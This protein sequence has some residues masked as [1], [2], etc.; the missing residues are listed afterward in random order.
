MAPLHRTSLLVLPLLLAVAAAAGADPGG[1]PAPEI[2]AEVWLNG[3]PLSR[4]ALLG[5][6][7]LV[8]FWTFACHN[9]QNVEPHVKAWHRRYA[10]RGLVV[11]AVHTPELGFERDLANVRRYVKEHDI[12]Y[13]VAVDNDFTTWR[14][15]GN[16]AWPAF[17]L[18][19]REGTIQRASVGEGG[20]AEMEALIQ[21]L[22]RGGAPDPP[23]PDSPAEAP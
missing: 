15:F 16:W 20:Y 12:T 3:P 13:P 11:V 5:R 14:R 2:S 4:E 22:L 6:V 21:E 23:A 8:E 19:D 9:C 7:V 1:R 18:I 17:Y 10:E